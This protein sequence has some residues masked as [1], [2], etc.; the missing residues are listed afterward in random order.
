M[1]AVSFLLLPVLGEPAIV[2][3]QLLLRLL[4]RKASFVESRRSCIFEVGSRKICCL[5]SREVGFGF[6]MRSRKWN[7]T[8]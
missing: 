5:Q 6:N 2:I 3:R 7:V 8:T 4:N 1:G